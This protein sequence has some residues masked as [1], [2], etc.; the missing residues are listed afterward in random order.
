MLSAVNE[1]SNNPCM[2]GDCNLINGGFECCCRE[3]WTGKLCDTG[4]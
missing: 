2:N 4:L 3:G 1:C